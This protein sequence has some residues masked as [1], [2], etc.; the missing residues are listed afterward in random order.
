M[1]L[2]EPSHGRSPR[3]LR[4][5]LRVDLR[6]GHFWVARSL[7]VGCTAIA[8]RRRRGLVIIGKLIFVISPVNRRKARWSEVCVIVWL[9]TCA[10]LST[11][12]FLPWWCVWI[13]GVPST[14][15]TW[16]PAPIM[17]RSLGAIVRSTASCEQWKTG[18]KRNDDNNK[19]TVRCKFIRI[20]FGISYPHGRVSGYHTWGYVSQFHKWVSGNRTSGFVNGWKSFLVFLCHHWFKESKTIEVLKKEINS[21][22]QKFYTTVYENT[23]TLQW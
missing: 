13:V 20:Y 11:L 22:E 14:A 21:E 23:T 4:I 16:R 5:V 19:K 17:Y 10:C 18:L 6:G 12:C 3:S 8:L 1:H 7:R 15:L 9:H 2:I